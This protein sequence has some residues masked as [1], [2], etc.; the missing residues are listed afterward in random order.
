MAESDSQT[1]SETEPQTGLI[2]WFA[3]NHVAANLLLI[4]VIVAGIYSLMVVKK[5]SMPAFQSNQLIISMAYP[6]A[7]PNEVE[8][9]VVI[10]IDEA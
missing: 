10:K 4:F 6:G 2:A 3:H 8:E 5:E 9:G 1:M 7:A